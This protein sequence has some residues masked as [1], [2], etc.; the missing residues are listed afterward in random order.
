MVL[1][2]SCILVGIFTRL[3]TA[4]LTTIAMF[5]LVALIGVG[6]ALGL[7]P[8]IANVASFIAAPSSWATQATAFLVYVLS[9]VFAAASVRRRL[10]RSLEELGQRGTELE[11]VASQLRESE[12]HHR[13]LADNMTDVVFVQALDLSL[14][15]LSKSAEP[16]FG[17]TVD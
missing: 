3:R 4:L 2:A 7:L 5:L 8:D 10:T 14:T 1:T 13:L 9:V 17:R 12:E 16:L 15:Y 11:C 6:H